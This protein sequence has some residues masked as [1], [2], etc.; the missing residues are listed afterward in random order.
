MRSDPIYFEDFLWWESDTCA[1]YYVEEQRM[2]LSDAATHSM[3][4]QLR[5]DPAA[6]ERIAAQATAHNRL[7]PSLWTPHLREIR[8]AA[9][10]CRARDRLRPM[11]PGPC[12]Q[13]PGS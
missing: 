7:P 5:A 3:Y 1:T 9:E 8:A 2:V 10:V 4:T 11:S 6:L 12:G 13:T